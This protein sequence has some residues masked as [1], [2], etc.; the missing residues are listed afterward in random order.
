MPDEVERLSLWRSA[1]NLFRQCNRPAFVGPFRRVGFDY[2]VDREFFTSTKESKTPDIVGSGPSGWAVLELT[3]GPESKAPQLDSYR[4]IDPRFL[5]TYGLQVHSTSPDSFSGRTG[6]TDDGQHSQLV[7][8]ERLEIRKLELV[9][10]EELRSALAAS[11]GADLS[12][13]PSIPITLLPESVGKGQEIRRGV[14]EQ[15]LQVFG[16]PGNGKPLLSMVEDGLDIL[17]EKVSVPDKRALVDALRDHLRVLVKDFLPS[18]LALENDV[19]KP[20]K[21]VS[22]H[23]KTLEAVSRAV[24]EWSGQAQPKPL[25]SFPAQP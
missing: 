20:K 9:S 18:H 22:A 1:I 7:L 11:D 17:S 12:Q 16:P 5:S 14:S 15:V 23:P 19:L 10:N 8:R 3:T 6:D 2:V 24:R 25:E 13:L 21:G 4:L